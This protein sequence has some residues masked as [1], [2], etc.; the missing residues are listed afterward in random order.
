MVPSERHVGANNEEVWEFV[1]EVST[2]L[3]LPEEAIAEQSWL[4]AVDIHDF[5]VALED[6]QPCVNSSGSSRDGF[7]DEMGGDFTEFVFPSLCSG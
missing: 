5:S 7:S 4:E 1:Q 6:E 2:A 3:F